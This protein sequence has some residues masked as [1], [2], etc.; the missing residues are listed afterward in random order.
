[1]QASKPASGAWIGFLAMAFGV[2]GLI[3]AFSTF[4]AQLPFDRAM[5]RSAA[6]DQAVAAYRSADPQ[7]ALERLRPQL[8][9][10][11]ERL[12][13]A[14]SSFVERADAERMRMFGELH[15]EAESDG[16]RL[17]FV[18]AAFTVAAALFGCM[19]LSIVRAR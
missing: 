9:E 18:I 8:G 2:L 10:S 19:V 7:A 12:L 14:T 3:G 15:A 13:P 6:I 5:A 4:A 16:F 17:R 11:A 1:M